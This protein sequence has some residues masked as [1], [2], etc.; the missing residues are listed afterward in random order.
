VRITKKK[1][2]KAGACPR[3][4]ARFARL[5]PNGATVNAAN[6]LKAARGG[7]PMWWLANRLELIG[8][9][10]ERYYRVLD[11]L[12]PFTQVL[13]R[14]DASQLSERRRLDAT[15]TAL[16]IIAVMDLR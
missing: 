2:E 7:L 4:L 15:L 3:E 8:G 10:A 14:E 12:R 5:F 1:L 9:T 13:S 11:I 16:A 6:I